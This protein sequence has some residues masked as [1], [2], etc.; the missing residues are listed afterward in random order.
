MH[1]VGRPYGGETLIHPLQ[2]FQI[3]SLYFKAFSFCKIPK[4]E[5]IFNVGEGTPFLAFL[6]FSGPALGLLPSARP[7]NLQRSSMGFITQ[8]MYVDEPQL[9]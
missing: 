8:Y 1:H 7:S 4:F 2:T 3:D 5:I 9:S 6:G